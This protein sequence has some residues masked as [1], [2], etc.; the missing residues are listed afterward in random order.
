MSKEIV[1]NNVFIPMPVVLAGT[2]VDGKPNFMAVG[3]V[4][5]ANAQPPMIALGIGRSHHTPR[6]IRACGTFSVNVPCAELVEK[7]DYCGLVSGEKVDKSALFTVF[8]GGEKTAPMIEECP[9]CLECRLVREVELP[10]NSVFIGE[11]TG[12]YADGAVLAEGRVDITKLDPLLLSM[13][14][15]RYWRLGDFAAKAWSCGA[16][17][18]S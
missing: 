14:D 2:L 12:A 7:V 6:G 18:K 13:P 17:L 3:W 15:N 16:A 11:I 1:R 10:T 5:R 9:L 8:Y 4:M